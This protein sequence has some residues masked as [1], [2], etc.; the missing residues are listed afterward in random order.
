MSLV[1]RADMG[2]SHIRQFDGIE[3]DESNWPIIVTVFPASIQDASLLA[4]LKHLE[5]LM[6]DADARGDKLFFITDLTHMRDVPNATQRRYT[7]EW[8]QRTFDLQ[9]AASLG[10]A[11][12]TP[13]A[14]LRGIITA[15][16][17]FQKTPTPSFFVANRDE[18]IS[19]GISLLEQ[20]GMPLPHVRRAQ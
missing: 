15:V 12:V 16:F 11:Q 5:Q 10:A 7:G 13:S 6:R 20:A 17:W 14:V 4:V 18:A 19:K 1:K 2:E 9:R 8:I 3:V